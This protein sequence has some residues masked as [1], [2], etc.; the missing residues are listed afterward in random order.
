MY[1]I[2]FPM[3]QIILNKKLTVDS[4]IYNKKYNNFA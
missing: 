3:Q 4:S 2:Q 1:N